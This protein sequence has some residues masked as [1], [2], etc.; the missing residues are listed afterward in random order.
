MAKERTGKKPLPRNFWKFFAEKYWENKPTA[1][2]NALLP[3]LDIKADEIFRWLLA[4]S[5]IC[6]R[7]RSADGIKFYIDGNAQYVEEII[8]LLPVEKDRS[9]LG[10]HR[11][12]QEMFSDY[13]LVC[14]ELLQV[15]REK[16]PVIA[17]FTNAIYQH[18]G[19]PNRFAEIGLYL[20][21]YKKTPFGVHVDGCGVFSIPVIGTKTFRLWAPNFVEKHPS[22]KESHRYS[23]FKKNSTLLSAVPGDIV[24]WPSPYW[25]VAESEGEFSAT[26][27]LG[28]W[29]DKPLAK[30]ISETLEPLLTARLESDADL[31]SIEFSPDALTGGELIELPPALRRS[32]A[33]IQKLNEAQWQEAL[34]RFWSHKLST[35]GFKNPPRP[36][37]FDKMNPHRPFKL[38]SGSLIHWTKLLNGSF[39]ISVYG[40]SFQ[41]KK[42]SRLTDILK[43][44][45]DGKTITLGNNREEMKLFEFLVK[46]G[47]LSFS[48]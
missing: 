44:L 47:S 25:H 33:A 5:D 10:Y 7:T 4:Y 46:A 18:V 12:M 37:D 34:R 15:S 36:G 2:R 17:N 9:L 27:S 40:K 11:R 6:R 21:N 16:W 14:D 30:I 1:I 26:W 8:E 39:E 13:C 28:V 31:R 32:W 48:R 23:S 19:Y 43:R 45:N 29:V 38:V 42:H 20:G 22:L 3:V 41:I 24:Y 35:Q